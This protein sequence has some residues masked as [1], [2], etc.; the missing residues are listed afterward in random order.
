MLRDRRVS[1][2][3][4]DEY[5]YVTLAGE[6]TMFEDQVTA[7][8]DIKALAVRYN[9]PERGEKQSRD[10]FAK[11]ERVTLLLPIEQVIADGFE[12]E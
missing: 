6:V 8:A 12:D 10:L 3:V 2:C 9:G 4:E 11:Q 1:L 7:Q 5:R